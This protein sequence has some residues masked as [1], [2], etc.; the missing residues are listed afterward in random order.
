MAKILLNERNIADYMKRNK[1]DREEAIELI[2][3]DNAIEGG[4]ETEYDLTPEQVKNVQEMARKIDHAK[5]TVVKR[6]RKPNEIKEG[7]ISAL[8]EFLENECEF[9]VKEQVIYCGDVIITNKNRMIH[10]SCGDKEYDL[11]LIE[12]RPKK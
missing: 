10:F 3:Y 9:E 7:I 11:Q 2:K 12:K 5:P 8:A 1:C 6:E 4:E